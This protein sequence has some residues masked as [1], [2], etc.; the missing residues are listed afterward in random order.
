MSKENLGEEMNCSERE[1]GKVGIGSE[2]EDKL[3]INPAPTAS[4]TH[5]KKEP[6]TAEEWSNGYYSER[7]HYIMP[8][9][10]QD[11]AVAFKAGEANER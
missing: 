7:S 10:P 5:A 2:H 8:L 1:I 9:L 3:I 6:M 11:L 4:D